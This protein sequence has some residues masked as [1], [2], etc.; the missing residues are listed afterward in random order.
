MVSAACGA[1]CGRIAARAVSRCFYNYAAKT[2]MQTRAMQ[3]RLL[4]SKSEKNP[5]RRGLCGFVLMYCLICQ[6]TRLGKGW[7]SQ[8]T[9]PEGGKNST[10]CRA[11]IWDSGGP[12]S[13]IRRA[14]ASEVVFWKALI[15]ACILQQERLLLASRGIAVISPLL[16]SSHN[17]DA[18]RIAAS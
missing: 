9:D 2:P 5:C 1:F 13:L 18:D 6:P 4:R 12:N 14:A 11:S 3:A 17:S 8:R 16:A 15:G 10:S 7:S